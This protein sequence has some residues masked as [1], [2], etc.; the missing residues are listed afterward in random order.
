MR[1]TLPIKHDFEIVQGATFRPIFVWK[2]E[3]VVA[4]LTGCTARM[5]VR[6]SNVSKDILLELTTENGKIALNDP[7][8]SI[9]LNISA[10]ETAALT[11]ANG[12]Y[13]LELEFPEDSDTYVEKLLRGNVYIMREVTQ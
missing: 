12:V 8:G 4:D 1:T 6:S 2:P 3:G 5:Q 10:T 11:W 13:D 7:L 9:K